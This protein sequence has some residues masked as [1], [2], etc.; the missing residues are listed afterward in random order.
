MTCGDVAQLLDAF[1]DAEL[2]APTLLA[3][4]RHAG[5]CPS[6]DVAVR[7]L[8]TLHDSIERTAREDADA[9]DLSSVW[10]AVEQSIE[11]G[12]S[13]RRWM[14]RARRVP[15]W[16]VA[17]AAAASVFFWVQSPPA[18]SQQ[19]HQQQARIV[20]PRPNQTVIE[21]IN[22]DSPRFELRRE[23]KLGTTL[24]MVSTDGEEISR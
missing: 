2:P 22:S 6:C 4:A 24:I 8:T 13:W 1:V 20:P 10:P 5:A 17:L 21:R 3:V 16:G 9:L 23:R 11:R 15:A 19:Q 14:R 7:A 12:E 18:P